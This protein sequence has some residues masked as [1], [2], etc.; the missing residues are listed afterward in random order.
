MEIKIDATQGPVVVSLNGRLDAT[1]A[2]AFDDK[3]KEVLSKN[4]GNVIISLE[5]LEYVSSAG[6][7]VFLSSAKEIKKT[8]SQ[9]AF[10][11]PTENVF[12]VLKMS[13]M[14]TI[15]KIYDSMD[16]AKGSF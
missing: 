14:D 7:R 15:L 12:K 5:E 8:G 2:S 3:M 13:G 16:K 9:L 11:K 6:L 1:N 10:A 4:L